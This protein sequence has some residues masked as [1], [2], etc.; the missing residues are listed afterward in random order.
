MK[1]LIV[2]YAPVPRYLG[3]RRPKYLPQHPILKH[4]QP[5]YFPQYEKP[6]YRLT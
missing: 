5:T 1:V 4:P 2:Q 3:P 6:S